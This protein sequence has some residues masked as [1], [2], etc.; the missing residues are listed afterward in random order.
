MEELAEAGDPEVQLL[1]GVLLMK[2]EDGKA[3]GISW[4]KKSA[5]L[6]YLPAMNTLAW[7]LVTDPDPAVRNV[8]EAV[9]LASRACEQDGWKNSRYLNTLAVVYAEA[10]KEKEGIAPQQA[11]EN[12]AD[13]DDSTKDAVQEDETTKE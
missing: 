10:D 11:D 9:K 4:I 1:Y 13:E 5:D 3:K 7:I 12:Q 6:G 8:D 2:N